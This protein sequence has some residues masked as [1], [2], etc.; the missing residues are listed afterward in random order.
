MGAKRLPGSRPAQDVVYAPLPAGARG[1]KAFHNIL[2]KSQGHLLL[3]GR[4]LR[5]AL[6]AFAVLRK[7][8]TLNPTSL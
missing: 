3:D 7:F 1:A 4:L 2:V 8:D 6:T 5:P